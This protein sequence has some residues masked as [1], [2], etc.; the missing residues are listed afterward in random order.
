[1]T[2]EINDITKPCDISAVAALAADIWAEHYT[3]LIGAAQVAYMLSQFQSE[4]AIGKHIAEGYHYSAAFV[5]GTAAGYC[6]TRYEPD[7][8]RV[9]LSK[10]YVA[11][12]FRRQG[13]AQ[14]LLRHHLT[15]LAAWPVTSVWLTVNKHNAGSIAAYQRMGF[16]IVESIVTDI[17]GGYVMDDFRMEMKIT[18]TYE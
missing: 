11:A 14:S 2:L 13:V 8:R 7:K 18:H 4:T 17:G 6:A 3:P 15:A 9:F 16:V 1:M 5:D 12:P 10:I